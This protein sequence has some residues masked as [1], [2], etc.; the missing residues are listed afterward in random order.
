MLDSW[1]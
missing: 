1:V